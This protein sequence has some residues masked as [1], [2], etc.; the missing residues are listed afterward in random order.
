MLEDEVDEDG[1]VETLVV[2]GHN[3]AVFVLVFVVPMILHCFLLCET[4]EILRVRIFS[5]FQ[6]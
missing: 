1:D 6:L 5:K 3:Y 4:L 2:G